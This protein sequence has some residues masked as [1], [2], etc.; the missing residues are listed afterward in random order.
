[1]PETAG[2]EP[3]DALCYFCGS[4]RHYTEGCAM[5]THHIATKL[6]NL[7]GRIVELERRLA[8]LGSAAKDP[9]ALGKGG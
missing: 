4:N 7:E 8:D 5:S 3:N 6:R 1:M 9:H 2:V